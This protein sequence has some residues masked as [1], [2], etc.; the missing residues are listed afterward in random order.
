MSDQPDETAEALARLD[1]DVA[2][3]A[4]DLVEYW[5][6]RAAIEAGQVPGPQPEPDG[7]AAPE[8]GPATRRSRD[9]GSGETESSGAPELIPGA[10]SFAA[11]E[12]AQAPEGPV[13]T[14][15]PE[16]A[17]S[18]PRVLDRPAAHTPFA[19]AEGAV[20]LERQQRAEREPRRRWWRR[21][22]R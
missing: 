5:R 12:P 19:P 8:A 4:V 7:Y 2:D 6:R 18:G 14:G 13:V 11:A 10:P 1:A 21:R 22:R 20:V 17:D 9:D 15:P 16:P 3:G